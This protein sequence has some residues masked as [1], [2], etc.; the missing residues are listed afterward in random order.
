MKND[1]YPC[2]RLHY[3]DGATEDVEVWLGE[4]EPES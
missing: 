1:D 2:C 4:P 3:S